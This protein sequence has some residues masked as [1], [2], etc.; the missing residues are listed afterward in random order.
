MRKDNVLSAIGFIPED[1]MNENTRI[2]MDL[3]MAQVLNK[4]KV[5][6]K[7]CCF[8]WQSEFVGLQTHT[9]A[10]TLQA[11]RPTWLL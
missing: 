11:H 1:C 2:E 7:K 5:S 3:S 8:V 4:T 6:Q 9:H 10:R